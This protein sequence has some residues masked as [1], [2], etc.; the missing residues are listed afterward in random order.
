MSRFRSLKEDLTDWALLCVAAEGECKRQPQ[1]RYCEFAQEI[2]YHNRMNFSAG[3]LANSIRKIINMGPCKEAR[4]PFLVGATNTG[5]STLVDSVDDL[6]HWQQVFHLP[7]DSDQKFALRNWVKNKRFVYFD[8]YSPVEYA[9]AKV[10]T[11]TTFK[12]AFGGKYFEIQCP[13]NWSDGN[14]DFKWNRGVIFT[15]KEEGLWDPVR[16]VTS[17][18]ISHTQARV[19]MFRFTHQ[20]VRP[21]EARGDRD[22]VPECRRCFAKWIVDACASF[23]AGQIVQAP[24][25]LP[26]AGDDARS[27]LSLLLE[28]AH[29]PR[30]L[31]APISAEVAALGAA[32]V[33]EL[34]E[35]DWEELPSW[36]ELKALERRRILQCVPRGVG[37]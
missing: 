26:V 30:R 15:N 27:G 21:G 22:A 18:D 7:A 29:I 3:H 37:V 12:K 28:R 33:R 31:R 17:E 8:E 20:F 32:D 34:T 13:K 10:I 16:S 6:F 19:E 5:K 4:V 9:R 11:P 14:K 24:P 1:C 23:D 36:S 2:L 35:A 25:V